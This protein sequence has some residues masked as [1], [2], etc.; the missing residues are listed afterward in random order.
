MLTIQMC[1][2][3]IRSYWWVIV[4]MLILLLA[5]NVLAYWAH[6]ESITPQEAYEHIYDQYP[7]NT[8]FAEY[9]RERCET[10]GCR[11]DGSGSLIIRDS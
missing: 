4:V 6:T 2:T 5:Y 7:G 11:I 10:Y 1:R 9:V 8:E 3:Y